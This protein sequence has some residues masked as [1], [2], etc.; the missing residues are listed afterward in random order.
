MAWKNVQAVICLF[1]FLTFSWEFTGP[2]DTLNISNLYSFGNGHILAFEGEI[3]NRNPYLFRSRDYG[4]TWD[5]IKN[6]GLHDSHNFRFITWYNNALWVGDCPNGIFISND[7]GNTWKSNN[8]S[9]R[10]YS[11]AAKDNYFLVGSYCSFFRSEDYGKTWE[12]I[13]TPQVPYEFGAALSMMEFRGIVFA[14]TQLGV[15]ASKDWGRTWEKRGLNYNGAPGATIISL[16]RIDTLF[17]LSSYAAIFK[18]YNLGLNDDSWIYTFDTEYDAFFHIVDS[19]EIYVRD[20]EGG[21]DNITRFYYSSDTGKTFKPFSVA[22]SDIYCYSIQSDDKYVYAMTDKGI[23]RNLKTAS[24]V[25]ISKN[26]NIQN[27][28]IIFSTRNK[29][30][31]CILNR[32][33]SIDVNLF[34]LN[35]QKIFSHKSCMRHSGQMKIDLKKYTIS[36]G[37]YIIRIDTPYY[38][39][40]KIISIE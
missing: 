18:S 34:K 31:T 29:T 23:Y 12:V 32:S 10:T 7:S 13:Y 40:S 21:S 5:T 25:S 33:S 30:I 9:T 27:S 16:D 26:V 15:F 6:T 39:E 2:S 11:F 24:P 37:L 4:N 1:S 3:Y 19:S 20:F 38:T 8:N 35:G 22:A 14:G 28:S 17:F 36:S